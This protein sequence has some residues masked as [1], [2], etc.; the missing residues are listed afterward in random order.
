MFAG[1]LVKTHINPKLRFFYILPFQ[2]CTM[3]NLYFIILIS[4]ISFNCHTSKNVSTT[5]AETKTEIKKPEVATINGSWE[6]QKLWSADTNWKVKPVLNF[7]LENKS[8]NGNTGCNAV[9]GKFA[10]TNGTLAFDKQMITTKMA[11]EG[12]RDKTF[13]NILLKV[14]T[15]QLEKDILQLSQDEIALM[16]LKRKE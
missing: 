2:F 1:F 14:N 3:K 16:T 10:F 6:L 13:I 8:F 15:W 12:Y 4:F 7:D 9:S 11:C 5:K